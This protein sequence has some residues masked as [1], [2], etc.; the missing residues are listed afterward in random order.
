MLFRSENFAHEKHSLSVAGR[1]ESRYRSFHFALYM[2]RAARP[3]GAQCNEDL[4]MNIA[5][6]IKICP[7]PDRTCRPLAFRKGDRAQNRTVLRKSPAFWNAKRIK[8]LIKLF[9]KFA[10]DWGQRP[11]GLNRRSRKES[12]GRC[13]TRPEACKQGPG[14]F[15]PSFSERAAETSRTLAYALRAVRPAVLHSFPAKL[16]FAFGRGALPHTPL[17]ACRLGRPLGNVPPGRSGP[18]KRLHRKLLRRFAVVFF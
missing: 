7:W 6:R 11:Q 5:K 18:L 1:D 4:E 16:R 12:Q 14:R 10:G 3:R 17:L 8:V 15:P 13:H 2:E 9:Q